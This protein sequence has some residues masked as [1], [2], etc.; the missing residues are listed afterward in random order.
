M[1]S[2]EATLETLRAQA[3]LLA[4]LSFLDLQIYPLFAFH[5]IMIGGFWVWYTSGCIMCGSLGGN[6][7]FD[8]RK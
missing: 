1:I 5:D 3:N 8:L 7:I 2:G 6:V 4:I